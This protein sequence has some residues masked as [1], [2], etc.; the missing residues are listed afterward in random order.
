MIIYNLICK[1][2]DL[3]FDSWFSSSMEYEKLKKK[4]ILNC[5]VCNSINIEKNLMSPNLL[6][7]KN[8]NKINNQDSK[9]REMKKIIS[10]HQNFIKKNFDY[11]GENFTYE[12]RSIH[13]NDKKVSKGIYGTATKE[14]LKELKEEGIVTEMIPWVR[15]NTN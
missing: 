3:L 2:C 6:R 14:D 5:H 10:K 4:K 1:N 7:S 12:A 13:Y 9:S 8:N 11:V 15:D